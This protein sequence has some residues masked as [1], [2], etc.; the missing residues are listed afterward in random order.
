M[1]KQLFFLL[2]ALLFAF[3]SNA[4]QK[5]PEVKKPETLLANLHIQLAEENAFQLEAEIE[6]FG[7]AKIKL[8]AGGVSLTYSK[9]T[10]DSGSFWV[11]NPEAVIS[12]DKQAYYLNCPAKGK[13]KIKLDFISKVNKNALMRDCFFYLLPALVRQ[14]NLTL[15]P[16][17]TEPEITGC[18]SLRKSIHPVGIKSDCARYSGTL[19]GSGISCAV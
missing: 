1:F 2:A 8:L 18:I 7:P 10:S 17:N 16:Q 12:F 19:Q 4:E 13:Y 15:S 11:K 3:S 9:I 6:T 14:V 5:T